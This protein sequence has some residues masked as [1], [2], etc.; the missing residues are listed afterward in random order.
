MNTSRTS[1][2]ACLLAIGCL[3][4]AARA[5]TLQ[6]SD[7]L[8]GPVMQLISDDRGGCAIALQV[9][10]NFAVIWY[11]SKG[12]VRYMKTPISNAPALLACD[13]NNL[14]YCHDDGGF[15]R[16]VTVDKKGTETFTS[17]PGEHYLDYPA[18][19]FGRAVQRRS[20]SKG[21]FVERVVGA[22]ITLQRYSYK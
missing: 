1:L 13:K 8:G 5:V 16:I 14:V 4:L 9:G 3:S 11:D 18:I 15:Y 21:Y 7:S 2:L 6:W 20:D 10:A 12:I 17:A 19:A 22:N